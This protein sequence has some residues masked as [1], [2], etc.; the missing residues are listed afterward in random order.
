MPKKKT[1]R[2]KAWDACSRYIRLRD[3]VDGY[4]T[5]V[6]CGTKKPCSE[7]QASHL[8]DGRYNSI[9][10]EDRIIFAACYQ[11]NITKSGNKEVYIP[12]FIDTYGKELYD[13]MRRKKST[14]V[15]YSKTDYER[16]IWH[17][18]KQYKEL[19]QNGKV[20]L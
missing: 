17:F 1:P 8:L 4:C 2:D 5:C 11:C 15:K 12:W 3:S 19:E 9:L 6:T 7:M 13:N 18:K 14:P 10:L 16:Y 20:W